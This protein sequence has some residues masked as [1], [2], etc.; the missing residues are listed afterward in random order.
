[1]SVLALLPPPPPPPP[2]EPEHA[3]IPRV[4]TN[5]ADAAAIKR[6]DMDRPLQTDEA[7]GE[8]W[9]GRDQG[10][11]RPSRETGLTGRQRR[12]N[13]HSLPMITG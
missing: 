5:R 9:L 7:D 10:V 4:A 11:R 3:A 8:Q 2:D 1:M 12:T 13:V 6:L